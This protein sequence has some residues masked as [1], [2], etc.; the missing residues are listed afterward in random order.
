[1]ADT[2]RRL[3][4]QQR[5]VFVEKIVAFGLFYGDKGDYINVWMIKI[6]NKA[7]QIGMYVCFFLK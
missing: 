2:Y 1:M 7:N 6:M 4:Q 3:F 5:F